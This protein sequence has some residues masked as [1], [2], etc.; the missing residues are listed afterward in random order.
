MNSATGNVSPKPQAQT[1]SRSDGVS[2]KLLQ[3][4]ARSEN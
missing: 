3:N 4:Q 2:D 1:D